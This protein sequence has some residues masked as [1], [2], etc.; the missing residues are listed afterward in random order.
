LHF[1]QFSFILSDVNTPKGYILLTRPFNLAIAFLS[2]FMGGAVTGT[3]QPLV[4]LLLACFSATC[5]T[6]GA[7]AV[8]DYFD[9]DIDR[10]NKPERPL[11]SGLVGPKAAH[12]FSILCFIIGVLLGSLI[13]AACL[14]IAFMSSVLL[15]FYSYRLKRTMVWGN[16]AVALVSGMAFVF[17]GLAVGRIREAAVVGTFAFLF[18]L[19]R[20]MI[21]DAEDVEGDRALG[22]RTLPIVRGVHATLVWAALVMV[23]LMAA[24]VI[25]YAAGIFGKAYLVTVLLGVDAFLIFVIVSMFSNPGPKHL[26]KLAAWMKGDMLLGLLAVF[27]G[28]V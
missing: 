12:R 17:G 14:S 5:I 18:H 19:A 4:K 24:T 22:L 10:I 21:K 23:V 26:R 11:P 16:L 7:N 6:A 27:L 15:Y 28:K 9:I 2:I 3:V 8:N 20:E 13:D 25:P 1:R